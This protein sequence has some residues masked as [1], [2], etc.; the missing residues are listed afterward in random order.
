MTFTNAEGICLQDI[1]EEIHKSVSTG[2]KAKRKTTRDLA[3]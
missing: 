2:W 3:P 1:V